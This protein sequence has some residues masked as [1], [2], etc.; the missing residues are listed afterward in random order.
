MLSTVHLNCIV[1]FSVS[2]MKGGLVQ[3]IN[4]EEVCDVISWSIS[5]FCNFF[6]G[7]ELKKDNSCSSHFF[8]CFPVLGLIHE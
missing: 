8:Y 6:L 3:A 1:L 4:M 5:A 7:S 2:Y